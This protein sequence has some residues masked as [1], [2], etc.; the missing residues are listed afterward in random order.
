[1]TIK[2]IRQLAE[3]K[4]YFKNIGRQAR[5]K[6]PVA[7]KPTTQATAIT[8]T[9]GQTDSFNGYAIAG[10]DDKHKNGVLYRI[11]NSITPEIVL[12]RRPAVPLLSLSDSPTTGHP[13]R[14]QQTQPSGILKQ[15]APALPM[16][17]PSFPAPPAPNNGVIARRSMQPDRRLPPIP[18]V[19]FYAKIPVAPSARALLPPVEISQRNGPRPVRPTV[20]HGSQRQSNPASARLAEAMQ[21]EESTRPVLRSVRQEFPGASRLS[22]A[23]R[24]RPGGA[25]A[26]SPPLTPTPPIRRRTEKP[27]VHSY[28]VFTA[29]ADTYRQELQGREFPSRFEAHDVA[30]DAF[31][32]VEHLTYD[33]ARV[34][35]NGMAGPSREVFRSA[36][37]IYDE[38]ANDGPDWRNQYD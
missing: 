14:L 24:E 28:E 38:H 12:R 6:A 19:R 37:D 5:R 25:P 18:P 8:G 26:P 20:I 33:R 15:K 31:G 21:A 27:P 36:R 17:A 22:Q 29:N 1:M 9:D 2:D 13:G 7:R 30:T 35:R 23:F 16:Y 10:D 3:E 11:K 32:R 34:F 4:Q